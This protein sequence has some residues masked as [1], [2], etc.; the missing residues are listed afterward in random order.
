MLKIFIFIVISIL[1]LILITYL[2]SLIPECSV[3]LPTN[4]EQLAI[5]DGN[6]FFG[7]AFSMIPL[8]FLFIVMFV[9]ELGN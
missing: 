6:C 1:Y 5:A 8:V 2:F 4:N 3:V 9:K 7:R